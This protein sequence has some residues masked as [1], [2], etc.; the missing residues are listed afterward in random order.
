M[1]LNLNGKSVGA[2]GGGSNLRRAI[3]LPYAR[4]APHVTIA[5]IDE[6]QGAKAAAEA[7]AHGA[8]S[9]QV[10]RTDVTKWE[11]AQTMVRAVEAHHGA[12]DVL[13]NN[14]GWTLDRLFME[15]ERAEWEKEVQI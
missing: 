4:E 1:D 12:V 8:A 2:T 3:S 6:A 14:V 9:A 13:V 10:I 7:Q 11:S 5:E 15:K